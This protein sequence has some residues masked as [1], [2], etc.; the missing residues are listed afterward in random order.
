LPEVAPVVGESLA[1][2]TVAGETTLGATSAAEGASLLIPGAT[3]TGE[4]TALTGTE[5]AGATG[6]AAQYPTLSTIG[7][8]AAPAAAGY[9]GA[10]LGGALGRA[11]GEAIGVG[12]ESEQTFIGKVGGGALAGAY[13]GG[14]YGAAIGAT[15]GLID[16]GFTEGKDFI[17]D[18]GETIGDAASDLWDSTFGSI[19]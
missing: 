8:Y 1:P 19:F 2:L 11:A 5:A 12:G 16:W 17:S 15:V 18:V 6:F 4:T 3:L 7:S 9:V 14:P 13:V 10:E